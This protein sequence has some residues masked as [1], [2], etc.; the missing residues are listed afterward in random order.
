M[1]VAIIGLG[2]VELPLAAA[3]GAILPKLG[4]YHDEA[5]LTQLT[6]GEDRTRQ[7]SA[8]VFSAVRQLRFSADAR[9]L[10]EA[11]FIIIPVPTATD[12]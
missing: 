10:A 7:V 6:R 3:F 4:Y 1:T 12:P 2:Y 8:K 5:K 9:V 11:Q